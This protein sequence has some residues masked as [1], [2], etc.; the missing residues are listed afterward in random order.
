MIT[1][2]IRLL[3][4]IRSYFFINNYSNEDFILEFLVYLVY[5]VFINSTNIYL[6]NLVSIVSISLN[7]GFNFSMFFIF[8]CCLFFCHFCY[9]YLYLLLLLIHSFEIHLKYSLI[10]QTLFFRLTLLSSIPFPLDSLFFFFLH[11]T[12][13]MLFLFLLPF[14]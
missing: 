12:C 11:Q 5:I 6:I 10:S 3:I 4:K 8:I 2:T 7:L 14:L 13:L 9:F 1:Y